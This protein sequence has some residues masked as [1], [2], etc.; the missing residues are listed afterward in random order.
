MINEE[1]IHE[2]RNRA[3]SPDHP[4]LR[5]TAQNPDVFFQNREAGNIYY[6]ECPGTV[7]EMMD[8]F[9]K[10]TQRQYKLFDYYGDPKAER[11]A[12]AMG[13]GTDT[14]KETVDY[15][16]QQG[17]KVGL[18]IVRLYRHFDTSSLISVLPGKLPK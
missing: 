3:L 16:N 12:V 11:V 5:G 1:W 4:S 15:L 10:L 8:A 9:G 13:S 6:N 18:V 2:H 17:E 7:Q 14:L